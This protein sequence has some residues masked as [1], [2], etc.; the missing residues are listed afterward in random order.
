MTFPPD[1]RVTHRQPSSLFLYQGTSKRF[2][3]SASVLAGRYVKPPFFSDRILDLFTLTEQEPVPPSGVFHV[4][5]QTSV[6]FR[7]DKNEGV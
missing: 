5:G 1:T 3:T 4:K 2:E 7:V 6:T